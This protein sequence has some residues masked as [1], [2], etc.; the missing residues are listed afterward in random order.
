ECLDHIVVFGEAH[1]RWMLSTYAAYYNQA[2]THLAL[3]KD[4]PVNRAV[5]RFGRIIAIPVLAG[6][7]YQY[8]RIFVRDTITLYAILGG[9]HHHYAGFRFSVHTSPGRS[10]GAFLNPCTCPVAVSEQ[11]AHY[12]PRFTVGLF[13]RKSTW[14][15]HS[16]TVTALC[17]ARAGRL[18]RHRISNKFVCI[19]ANS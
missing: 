6:L 2:R 1:L 18:T 3:Q 8:V 5:Q 11:Q 16:C 10:F 12:D 17:A 4:A 14:T 13:Q 19:L 9:L 15:I 7:H